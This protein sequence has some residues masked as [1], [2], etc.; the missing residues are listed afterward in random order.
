MT[1]ENLIRT[2]QEEQL[3]YKYAEILP[4]V[5][6]RSNNIITQINYLMGK[7]TKSYQQ[8][9]IELGINKKKGWL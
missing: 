8:L 9:E 6:K 4:I 7:E 3:N 5:M 2:L 1:G